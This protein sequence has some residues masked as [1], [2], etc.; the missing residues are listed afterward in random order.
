MSMSQETV[1]GGNFPISNV[2]YDLITVI[3]EKSKG[4]EAYQRYV[5][6]AQGNDQLAN[7]FQQ[8]FEQDR[9]HIQQLQQQLQQ[10]LSSQ[11]GATA[12]STGSR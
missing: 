2:A 1:S 5:K 11:A 6:D 9:H 3:Y 4:L 7:L 10:V 12:G 8:I